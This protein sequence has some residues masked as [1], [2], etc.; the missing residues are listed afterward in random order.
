M[1]PFPELVDPLER[2]D[3]QA[4]SRGPAIIDIIERL[5]E[6]PAGKL[7]SG[8]RSRALS[9]R[10]QIAMDLVAV[11]TGYSSLKIGAMFK[12]DHTT[13]FYARRAVAIRNQDSAVCRAEYQRAE[14]VL[15]RRFGFV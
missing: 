3:V 12:R 7:I 13:V 14:A 4:S 10:R 11:R 2:I 8:G 15:N 5:F 9:W 6:L 1:T